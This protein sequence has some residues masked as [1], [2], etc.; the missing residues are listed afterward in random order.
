MSTLHSILAT[1]LRLL[2][3]I[4]TFVENDDYLIYRS[5]QFPNYYGGNGLAL[6]HNNGRTLHDWEAIFHQHFEPERFEHITFSF[7]MEEQFLPLL[8]AARTAQYHC[9][10]SCYMAATTT[11]QNKPISPEYE[12]WEIERDEDWE[13]LEQFAQSQYVEGD[14]FDPNSTGPDRL[15]E[16]TRY[17]SQQIGIKWFAIGRVGKREILARL[18]VFKHDTICR[19]QDVETGLEWRRRGLAT[20]LVR[21]AVH[22]SIHTLGATAVALEAD[23]DYHAIELYRKLGFSECG[24][25]ITLMHYPIRNP[26]FLPE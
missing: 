19:L 8:E 23:N 18:G 21:Y 20:A 10:I 25:Q 26:A 22:Y 17:V 16:K 12:V 2:E 3:P 15:F 9:T 14:W 7:P 11:Q 6:Q 13:R 1:E 24:K 5:D 4:C